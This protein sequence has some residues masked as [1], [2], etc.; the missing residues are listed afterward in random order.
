MSLLPQIQSKITPISDWCSFYLHEDFSLRF[1]PFHEEI[2]ELAQ[3]EAIKRLV[4]IAPRG[5]GK[6]MGMSKGYPL[7]SICERIHCKRIIIL[8]ATGQ[9]AEHWLREIKRELEQNPWI[10]SKYGDVRTDKWTESHIICKR[11]D[12]SI[13]ELMAKGAGYQLRG[14]HPDDIVIDDIET[15]EGVRSSDQRDKMEDWF[16][17]DVI[18]VLDKD[19]RL[20][21]IGTLLHDYALLRDVMDREKWTTREFPAIQPDGSSL[22]PE[23]W[24]IEALHTREDEIGK[25]AFASEFQGKPMASDDS[26]FE[27][28]YFQPYEEASAV[29]QKEKRQGLYSV[30]AV[31][32]AI[33]RRDGADYTAITTL[34]ANYDKSNPKFYI[35]K[36]GTIRGRW[37]INRQVSEIVRLYDKFSCRAVIIEQVAY[38]QALCDELKRYMDDHRRQIQIIPVRPDKDKIRRTHAVLP[39][40]ERGRVMADLSD[41]M[42]SKMVDEAVVFPSGK[43]DDLVDALVYAVTHLKRWTATEYHKNIKSAL[44][45]AW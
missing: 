6:S 5:F 18:N 14:F 19:Q 22:W 33:S 43:Y 10:L 32:P 17:K 7:Y 37:P 36:D 9:L 12:G 2:F 23:K 1:A 21:M 11:K 3:N 26:I 35:R 42:I 40:F 39:E 29:F 30:L 13:I 31:D 20:I 15:T 34:S 41:K 44:A 4:I 27:R 25:R 24:P 45:G 38:Q 28:E 16:N 8:S